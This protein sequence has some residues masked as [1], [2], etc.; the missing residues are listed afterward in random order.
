METTSEAVIGES[1]V[2]A[3]ARVWDLVRR[4][5]EVLRHSRRLIEEA[6]K[7]GGSSD[8]EKGQ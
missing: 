5:R 6:R 1:L 2:D 7:A 8:S 4:S 3:T